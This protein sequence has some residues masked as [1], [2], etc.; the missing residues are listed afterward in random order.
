MALQTSPA[1]CRHPGITELFPGLPEKGG[2][3]LCHAG[4]R[5]LCQEEVISLQSSAQAEALRPN[6]CVQV[7]G[8]RKTGRIGR[9]KERTD[10]AKGR[11]V[12]KVSCSLL[13]GALWPVVCVRRRPETKGSQLRPVGLVHWQASWPPSTPSGQDVRFSEEES[14]PVAGRGTPSR[15]SNWALIN[16]LSEE[17]HVLTKQEISLERAPGWRAGG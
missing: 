17:T 5:V 12:D 10:R 2:L 7:R 13:V 16:E 14:P 1:T 11:E 6:S 8:I 3:E 9:A 15:A 4:I